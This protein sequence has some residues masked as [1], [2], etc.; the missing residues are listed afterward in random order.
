MSRLCGND[1]RRTQGI[2]VR[3]M[4]AREKNAAALHPW[5][6]RGLKLGLLAKWLQNGCFNI[7]LSLFA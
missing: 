2:P 6:A 3:M 4:R 1:V 5:K 7:E